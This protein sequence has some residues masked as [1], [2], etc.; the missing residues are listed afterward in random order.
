MVEAVSHPGLPCP[1][2]GLELQVYQRSAVETAR[3]DGAFLVNLNTGPAMTTGVSFDPGSE[4]AHWF[5]VDRAIAHRH[6]VAVRGPIA[7]SVL[8]PVPRLFVLDA[9]AA[10]LV[11]HAGGDPLGANSVLNACRAL[12][13]AEDDTFVSKDDAAAWAIARGVEPG[14]VRSALDARRA[15]DAPLLPVEAVRALLGR[16][17]DAVAAAAGS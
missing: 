7:S 13:F 5:V 3:P 9:L 11:W 8:A 16:V 12:R 4:P 15:G 17:A 2:R 10:S 14:L 6:G 1:A